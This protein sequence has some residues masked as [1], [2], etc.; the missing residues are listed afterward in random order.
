MARTVIAVVF[1]VAGAVVMISIVRA[2]SLFNGQSAEFIGFAFVGAFIS[3]LMI[4]PLLGSQGF[5][6]VTLAIFG[7]ILGT[8]GGAFIG[9]G[10]MFGISFLMNTGGHEG[11]FQ[12]GLDVVKISVISVVVV[13]LMI[14]TTWVGPIWAILMVIVHAIAMG[15]RKAA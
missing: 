9:S 14:L 4:A 3:G 11:V 15:V 12:A 8:W 10:L 13:S 5:G 1:G 2:E 7:A 6:S